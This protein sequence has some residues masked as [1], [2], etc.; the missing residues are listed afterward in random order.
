MRAL[1][2][3]SAIPLFGQVLH[4]SSIPTNNCAAVA[5]SGGPGRPKGRREA[6]LPWTGAST[7]ACLRLF[8]RSLRAVVPLFV[9]VIVSN[10]TAVAETR[11]AHPPATYATSDPSADFVEDAS[12]RFGVPVRTIRAVINVESAGDVRARSPK[13]AMGL[14]QIMPETW[15]ELRLRYNLGSDP[16]DS[17]DNIFAGTAYLRELHDQYGS[18]GFLAAYNAGP[19]RYE[20]HLAGRPLPAETQAYLQKLAPVIGNDIA[21]SSAVASLRPSAGS[22]FIVRSESS[23]G[24]CPPAACAPAEPGSNGRF[25]SRP[26]GRCAAG[27]WT[28]RREI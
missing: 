23:K 13:G 28:V 14:M 26:L 9:A 16:Y 21:A 1:G 17:H 5:R 20:E 8:E 11:L 12:R 3:R 19:G 4:H 10:A 6:A 22:L 2:S 7:A 18:P 25:R 15:A 27:N 24:R